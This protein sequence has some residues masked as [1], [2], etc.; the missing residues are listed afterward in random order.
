M[1]TYEEAVS[2]LANEAYYSYMDGEFSPLT[3]PLYMAKKIAWIY[4]L[5]VKE[6]EEAVIAEYRIMI[7]IKI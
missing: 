4:E 7:S 2:M 6:V 1:K 3:Q 5:P